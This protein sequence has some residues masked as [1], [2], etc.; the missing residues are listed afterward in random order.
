MDFGNRTPTSRTTC[1]DLV[2]EDLDIVVERVHDDPPA[3]RPDTT[4]VPGRDGTLLREITYDARTITLECRAFE[5]TWDGFEVLRDTLVTHLMTRGELKLVLRTHPHEYY[6]AHLDSIT[7]GDRIGGTGIG[8]FE[9]QFTANDPVRYGETKSVEVPSG[10][11]VS[12]KVEG[13]QPAL[14]S[15]EASAAVR[16]GGSTVWGVRFDEQDFAHI[17]TGSDSA[18]AISIDGVSRTAKVAGATSMITLDS[19]WPVL[20]PGR[21]VARMDEGAGAATL[22]WQERSL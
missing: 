12:F 11:S 13:N 9:L 20:T 7:E 19:D 17:A 16:S 18:R 8:Y 15:I 3:A 10:G 21:H 14:A 2:L 6:L 4:D 1:G 5:K 22:T